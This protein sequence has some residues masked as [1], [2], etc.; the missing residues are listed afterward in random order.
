MAAG[1]RGQLTGLPSPIVIHPPVCTGLS[2]FGDILFYCFSESGIVADLSAT[3]EELGRWNLEV[4][5]S[6]K[7][8]LER[9]NSSVTSDSLESSLSPPSSADDTAGNAQDIEVNL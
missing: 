1:A 8:S 3:C 2:D 9:S 4:Q 5:T 7:R 6:E